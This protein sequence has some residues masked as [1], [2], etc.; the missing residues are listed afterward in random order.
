MAKHRHLPLED[1]RKSRISRTYSRANPEQEEFWE[2]SRL[3]DITCPALSYTAASQSKK[4][5]GRARLM[6]AVALSHTLQHPSSTS[7]TQHPC[8]RDTPEGDGVGAGL[9]PLAHQ[10]GSITGH[11][12]QHVLSLGPCEVG[13]VPP[14]RGDIAVHRPHTPS[15]S[16]TPAPKRLLES[17]RGRQGLQWGRQDQSL[18]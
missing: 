15:P 10:E 13:V 4:S 2:C 18:W 17:S 14:G 7:S 11:P 5:S 1:G 8:S 3:A 16:H 12:H 9:A 6:A